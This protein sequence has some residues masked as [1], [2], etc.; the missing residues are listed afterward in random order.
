MSKHNHIQLYI[1]ETGINKD[2]VRYELAYRYGEGARRVKKNVNT[3]NTYFKNIDVKNHKEASFYKATCHLEGKNG[4]K[5]DDNK[6]LKFFKIAKNL[7]HTKTEDHIKKI[8]LKLLN[9][10]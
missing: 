6:A 1:Y 8:E 9:Q 7:G 10:K 4:M 2:D 5:I 3:F